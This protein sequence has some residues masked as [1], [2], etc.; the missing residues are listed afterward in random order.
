MLILIHGYKYIDFDFDLDI[1][2]PAYDGHEYTLTE[3]VRRRDSD[4]TETP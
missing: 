4:A 2:I 3:T 1:D